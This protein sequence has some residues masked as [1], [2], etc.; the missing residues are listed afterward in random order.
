MSDAA[1][2]SGGVPLLLDGTP[3]LLTCRTSAGKIA[4]NVSTVRSVSAGNS[5]SLLDKTGSKWEVPQHAHVQLMLL[6]T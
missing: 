1:H 4:C 6:H 3:L 5:K 2:Q